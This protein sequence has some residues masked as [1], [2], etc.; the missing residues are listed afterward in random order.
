MTSNGIVKIADFDLAEFSDGL[1]LGSSRHRN[2]LWTPPENLWLCLDDKS[3]RPS[4]SGD[5]YSFAVTCIE[6]SSFGS[7]YA[8]HFGNE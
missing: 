7:A 2:I 5:I 1:T 6:V 8:C 4:F 3:L